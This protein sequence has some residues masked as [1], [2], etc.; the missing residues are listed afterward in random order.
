MHKKKIAAMTMAIIISNFS[1]TTLE[2]LADEI[3]NNTSVLEINDNKEVTKAAVNKFDLY[4][5]DKL[6]DYNSIFKIDNSKIKSITNNGG[7]YS[8]SS[9]DKA[10]DNN[11]NTH[12]ETGKQ[13]N[14]EFTNEVVFTFNETT[15]LNRIVYAARQ[16]GAKGKGFAQ[17]FEI[18]SSLT[19]DG[20]DFILVSEGEYKGSTG[21]LVEIKFN[22]AKFKRLKFKFKK[23]NQEWASASEFMLYKEDQVY[24]KVKNLFTDSNMNSIN[25]EF[26]SIE[27]INVLEEEAKNHPLYEDFKE[28]IDNAK[29]F[30]QIKKY[31]I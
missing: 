23:A 3:S 31:N 18:Y 9:I 21:D 22:S 20:D 2:V 24:D 8:D 29:L 5:S 4:N 14:S 7:Q 12:W 27:K 10:I 6:N 17:E 25:E 13:N 1:A 15:D 19:D 30:F 28:D 11:L 26:N 16:D